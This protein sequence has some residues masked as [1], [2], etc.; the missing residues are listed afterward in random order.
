MITADNLV[1]YLV[2]NV[3]QR[4]CAVHVWATM[5]WICANKHCM[6]THV[7]LHKDETHTHTSG[8]VLNLDY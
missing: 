7:S 4:V 2:T 6:V 5:E 3:R 8:L 1:A